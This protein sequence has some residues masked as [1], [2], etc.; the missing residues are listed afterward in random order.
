MIRVSATQRYRIAPSDFA[1]AATASLIL[2][3][4][5]WKIWWAP[6][7]ASKCQMEFNSAFKG[8][9][10]CLPG[11]PPRTHW[12][13]DRRRTFPFELV[14]ENYSRICNIYEL[15]L[16]SRKTAQFS[17]RHNIQTKL[18]ETNSSRG[19]R[20]RSW[21]RHCA[22]SRKVAGS[23]LDSVIGFFTDIILPASLWPW[24]CFSL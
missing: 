19:T 8:L 4:L 23:I 11:C 13:H 17:W 2:N 24:G 5:M 3:P 1:V 20:W 10:S 14:S 7:N 12:L 22:T 21:L 9:T 6:N 15:R 18:L 16:K